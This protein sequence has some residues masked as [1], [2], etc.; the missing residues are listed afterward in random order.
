LTSKN[1]AMTTYPISEL[2]NPLTSFL[3]K[4]NIIIN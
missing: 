3:S 4:T 2:K 1:T